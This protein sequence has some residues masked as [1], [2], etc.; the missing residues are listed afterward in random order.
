MTKFDQPLPD[1]EGQNRI[2][3]VLLGWQSRLRRIIKAL[4]LKSHEAPLELDNPL[5]LAALGI[6]SSNQSLVRWVD[7]NPSPPPE[8]EIDDM[9]EP[10]NNPS[11]RLLR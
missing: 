1:T 8:T 4:S 5:V 7:V 2:L 3:P 6:I 9:R 10:Q 11:E